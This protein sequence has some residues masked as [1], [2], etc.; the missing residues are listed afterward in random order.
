M[1]V[2]LVGDKHRED[3]G[4]A[5]D[6]LLGTGAAHQAGVITPEEVVIGGLQPG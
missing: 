2:Y 4:C 1:V 6:H 3:A 5:F